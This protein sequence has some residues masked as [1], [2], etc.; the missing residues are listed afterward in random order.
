MHLID[1]IWDGSRY[2]EQNS[3][4]PN[5]DIRECQRPD[6]DSGLSRD[7]SPNTFAL[8]SWSTSICKAGPYPLH[9]ANLCPQSMGEWR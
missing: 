3:L 8:I 4:G 1:G 6:Q 5:Q 9:Q 7:S 2:K